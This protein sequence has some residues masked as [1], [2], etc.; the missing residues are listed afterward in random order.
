M[1]RA[2][3]VTSDTLAWIWAYREQLKLLDS[4]DAE[5]LHCAEATWEVDSWNEFLRT[6]GLMRGRH[7]A[8]RDKSETI[9]AS[10]TELY[11][12]PLPEADVA[13]ELTRRWLESASE[14]GR[15]VRERKD[16]APAVLLSMTSK[17]LWFY[18]PQ[19]MTMFDTYAFRA[20]RK[21]NGFKKLEAKDYLFAFEEVFVKEKAS[22]SA[23]A[24]FVD[25]K[26][27]YLRRVLDKRLW[28]RGSGKEAKYL[29][30][31]EWSLQRAPL[32]K[33]TR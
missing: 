15:V 9:L 3:E 13:K 11:R 19:E 30:R 7:A 1:S 25:R 29:K 12:E 8:L 14:V 16:G 6:Y 2:S 18:Q 32:R 21:C 22:I 5:G 10:L 31:F 28:L 20:I 4:F 26:Y 33:W 17:L 24:A 27:P 23:A